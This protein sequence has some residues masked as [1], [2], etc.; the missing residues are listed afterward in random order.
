MFPYLRFGP[1]LLQ[2]PLLA[3]LVGLWIGVSLV[4][5]ESTRLKLDLSTI[6]NLI[7]Y[8]LIAG[9]IGARL[10]YALEF[11]ALYSSNPLS[12]LALTPTMLSPSMGLVVGLITFVIFMQRKTLPIH[13]TLDALVPG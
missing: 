13:S 4:E 3:L 7:F 8:G 2:M 1:F 10:G 5:R 9:L 6:S 11:P 12:L